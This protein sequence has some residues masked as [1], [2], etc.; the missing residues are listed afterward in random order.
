MRLIQPESDHIRG[1]SLQPVRLGL[2]NITR[3]Y[4]EY[5]QNAS[6]SHIIITIISFDFDAVVFVVHLGLFNY[7]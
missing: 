1:F 3:H 4:P 2:Q 5:P 7:I 6:Y